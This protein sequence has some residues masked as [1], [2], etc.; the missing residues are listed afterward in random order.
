MPTTNGWDVAYKI[1]FQA[2][3]WIFKSKKD[4]IKYT[5][6][7]IGSLAFLRVSSHTMS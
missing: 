1:Q 2:L 4:F 6:V 5:P 3:K 7:C